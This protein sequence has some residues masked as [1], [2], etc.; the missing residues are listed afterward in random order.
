[1]N[2]SNT[3]EPLYND[4]KQIVE[5]E[6]HENLLEVLK[7]KAC[8]AEINKRDQ[9]ENA[10][11]SLAQ[12][13]E[14]TGIR[15]V[16]YETLVSLQAIWNK[17]QPKIDLQDKFREAIGG[18]DYENAFL[19]YK[20]LTKQGLDY[21]GSV[22]IGEGQII[23]L[24]TAKEYMLL[25]YNKKVLTLYNL[26]LE[27]I[28][29]IPIPEDLE[30][31]DVMAPFQIESLKTMEPGE[32]KELDKRVW[33]LF[34]DRDDE[35]SILPLNME[36][37]NSLGAA[38]H[39]NIKLGGF[40][41]DKE[42]YISLHLSHYQ[43]HLLMVSKNTIYY[44]KGADWKEWYTTRNQN[45][46]TAFES[47]GKGFWV[48]HS[49]SKVFILKDLKRVGRREMLEG[50]TGTINRI[51]R[52][53]EFVI[54]FGDNI[55]G[56]AEHD[57]NLVMRP[58]E[59]DCK[60]IQAAILKNE[61]VLIHLANGMLMAKELK[62]GNVC[63]QINLGDIYEMIIPFRQYVYCGKRSGEIKRF[64]IPDFSPM[65]KELERKNFHVKSA[66]VESGPEAPVRYFSEFIGRRELLNEIKDTGN[67]HF[68]LY[69]EP[70]VGKTSLLN[71]LRDTLSENSK[72]CFVDYAQLL[73]DANS[74][75]EF[76]KYFMEKCLSQHLMNISQL[77][78]ED[79]YQALL[80]MANKIKCSREFCVICLE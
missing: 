58:I 74:Y 57:G 23:P 52:W 41:F 30:I 42:I 28:T 47:T 32:A 22:Q 61:S 77:S 31:I 69:G 76:E 40:Y 53:G 72:C 62:Q 6:K 24:V 14:R 10:L 5:N 79:G 35:I 70:R 60:I 56:V 75:E 68:L 78:F 16:L 49:N 20:E 38:Y 34:K 15:P 54:I 63:W 8:N 45:E 59:T 46:I 7:E 37:I 11:L 9:F 27:K 25:Q 33:I 44:K 4:L 17:D 19:M 2:G 39:H 3:S 66:R 51:T 1:M 36:E 12:N 55:L 67:T 73:K 50:Y 26:Q 65:E 29:N 80:A 48:G 64:E 13:I 43:D 71:V 18:E 21:I